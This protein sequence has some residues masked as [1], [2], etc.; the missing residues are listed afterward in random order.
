[1]R[2]LYSNQ[3]KVSFHIIIWRIPIKQ[4]LSL[5]LLNCLTARPLFKKSLFHRC[6]FQ[7]W[8]AIT[9]DLLKL[10]AKFS[11]SFCSK[12]YPLSKLSRASFII[13]LVS[14]AIGVKDRNFRQ[15]NFGGWLGQNVYGF[16]EIIFAVYILW[17]YFFL[18]I[19]RIKKILIYFKSCSFCLS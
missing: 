2:N 11:I 18:G 19:K 12:F 9:G 5:K 14:K 16:A 15:T 4:T 8:N 6:K 1:M 3:I 17:W 13:S 7:H 10:N